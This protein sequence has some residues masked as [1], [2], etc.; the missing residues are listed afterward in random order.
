MDTLPSLAALD[1]EVQQL[2][3]ELTPE[4][5]P[6]LLER[7]LKR[8]SLTICERHDKLLFPYVRAQISLTRARRNYYN[9]YVPPGPCHL[10]IFAEQNSTEAIFHRAQADRDQIRSLYR[11]TRCTCWVQHR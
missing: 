6:L 3:D 10:G 11:S 9:D 7:M 1:A 4:L 8:D 5:L 2:A